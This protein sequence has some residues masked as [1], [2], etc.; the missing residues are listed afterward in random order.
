MALS[1][2]HAHGY[3]VDIAVHGAVSYS[4]RTQTREVVPHTLRHTAVRIGKVELTCRQSS[5]FLVIKLL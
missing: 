2:W 3:T 4:C 1:L 5:A